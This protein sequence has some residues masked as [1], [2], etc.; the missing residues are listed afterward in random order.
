MLNALLVTATL[1]VPTSFAQDDLAENMPTKRPG[2]AQNFYGFQV[3]DINGKPFALGQLKGKV[4]MVVNTASRC[5]LTPQYAG[6][7]ALQKE[8]KDEGF[9][10]IAFPANDFQNQEPGTNEEI[11]QFCEQ[12]YNISFPLMSKIS[13]RGDAKHPLYKWLIA[14]SDRPTDEIEWNFAKFIIGRD[15]KVLARF[16]PRE[17]PES[18]FIREA[19][20]RALAAPR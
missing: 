1:F 4:V 14:N 2:T 9:T 11:K 12:N 15:G 17:R 13:V 10:V 8:Y 5:G 6:L 7:E 3:T 20:K 16:A 18:P 19:L